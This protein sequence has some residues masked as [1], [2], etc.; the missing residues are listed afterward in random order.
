MKGPENYKILEELADLIGPHWLHPV[1]RSM[2]AGEL[3]RIRWTD[4]ENGD[5]DEKPP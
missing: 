4:G 1:E 2:R 5:I 3:T